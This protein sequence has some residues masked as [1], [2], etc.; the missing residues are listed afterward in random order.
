MLRDEPHSKEVLSSTIQSND[1]GLIH[2]EPIG[3][4]SDLSPARYGYASEAENT[5]DIINLQGVFNSLDNSDH[6][7]AMDEISQWHTQAE[8]ETAAYQQALEEVASNIYFLS[9]DMNKGGI[10]FY[11]TLT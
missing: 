4:N 1:F 6:T 2:L 11:K 5:L 9:G 8:M 7:V 10:F 3:F